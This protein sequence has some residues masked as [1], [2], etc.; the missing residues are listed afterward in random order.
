MS[1]RQIRGPEVVSDRRP[2]D[3]RRVTEAACTLDVILETDVLVEGSGPRGLGAA[4]G[5]GPIE[6]FDSLDVRAVQQ[7]LR[8]QG[9]RLD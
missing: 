9:V 2:T 7:D 6:P 8:R 1:S 5:A 3:P 4:I